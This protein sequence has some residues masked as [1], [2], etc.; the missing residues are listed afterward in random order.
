MICH[1]QD[2][3]DP[4]IC[5]IIH[6]HHDDSEKKCKVDREDET[7]FVPITDRPNDREMEEMLGLSPDAVLKTVYIKQREVDMLALQESKEP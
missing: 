7:G 4:A 6:C 1:V 2:C 5:Y 3:I